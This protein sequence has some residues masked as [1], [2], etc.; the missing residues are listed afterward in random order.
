MNWIIEKIAREHSV[1]C[2]SWEWHTWHVSEASHISLNRDITAKLPTSF[3]HCRFLTSVVLMLMESDF[4][5]KC[6]DLHAFW[7]VLQWR[8][9]L[10][11]MKLPRLSFFIFC[12]ITSHTWTFK[13]LIWILLMNG[14]CLWVH[15]LSDWGSRCI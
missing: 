7:S 8:L 4:P 15:S 10:F 9:M 13:N 11:H 3:R 1:P 2:F 5:W 12:G 6:S 14:N